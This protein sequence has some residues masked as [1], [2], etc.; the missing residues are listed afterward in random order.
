ML[1]TSARSLL[2]PTGAALALLEPPAW[3]TING[4][5]DPVPVEALTLAPAKI[6]HRLSSADAKSFKTASESQAQA[7][8]GSWPQD[9]TAAASVATGAPSLKVSVAVS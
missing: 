6:A 3:A 9:G 5:L 1:M 4:V 7:S 2:A 8:P